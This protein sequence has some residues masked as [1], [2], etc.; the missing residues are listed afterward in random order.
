VE[1]SHSLVAAAKQI[2]DIELLQG[3]FP[4]PVLAERRFDAIFLVDVLEHVSDPLELVLACQRALSPDGV[5]AVITPDIGSLTA[6]LLGR[7]WW[8]LRLAHIGY[9]SRGCLAQL[10]RRAGLEVACCARPTW[11]LPVDYVAQR[12]TKYLPIG[13]LNGLAQR[14]APMRWLYR[15]VIPIN[16]R[17]SIFVV[18]RKVA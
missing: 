16:P 11:F 15:R 9:F 13:W 10:A 7:R 12:L 5:L 4:H 17:D 8:H 18:L 6:R 14:V 3:V 2:H 1:P